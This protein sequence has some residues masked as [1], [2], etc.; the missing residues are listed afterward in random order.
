[1]S[2]DTTELQTGGP[3]PES[4]PPGPSKARR[5]TLIVLAVCAGVFIWY[6]L[7]DR[8]TPYTDQARVNSLTIPLVSQ[9]PG[10]LSDIRVRLHS[11]VQKGDTLFVIDRRKYEYAVR[12]AEANL[13]QTAQNVG[14][15]DGIG[16]ERRRPSWASPGR[17]STGRSATAIGRSESSSSTPAR[18]PRPTR[19]GPRPPWIRPSSACRRPNRISR[20]RQGGARRIRR[21]QCPSPARRGGS[22]VGTTESC[23]HLDPRPL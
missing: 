11:I 18:C 6:L 14:A 9:V 17:N 16:Q 7:A 19:T 21:R 5:L 15:R 13:D 3:T 1:M 22:R 23:L 20:S 12:Q 4:G 2:D 10:Y 8:H